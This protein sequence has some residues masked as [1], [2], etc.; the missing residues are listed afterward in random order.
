[1]DFAISELMRDYRLVSSINSHP[2]NIYS[3]IRKTYER[4]GLE[5]DAVYY[6]SSCPKNNNDLRDEKDKKSLIR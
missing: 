3:L 4:K 5:S 1:M 2:M 6:G